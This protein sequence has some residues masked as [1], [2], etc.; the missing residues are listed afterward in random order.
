[1]EKGGLMLMCREMIKICCVVVTLVTGALVDHASAASQWI[2]QRSAG[3]FVCLSEFPLAGY[4]VLFKELTM[5][6]DDLIAML[7]VPAARETVEIYLFKSEASYRAYL[8]ER[9]PDV[10]Y[11]K[12]MF[13]KGKGPGRVFTHLSKDLATNL[14]HEGTHALL[15]AA[16]P[17]VPLWLDEGLAEYFEVPV[18]Q[19]TVGNP[20]LGKEVWSSRLGIPVRLAALEEKR[21]IADMTATDYRHAWAWVHFMLHS[22]P[23]AHEELIAYFADIQASTPPG[24]LSQRLEKRIPGAEKKLAQHFR[25]W[26]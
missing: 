21:D 22:S 14:R 8:R 24:Q 2:D 11:R 26:R 10:P 1:L 6:Q 12:A 19:R 9:Y 20:H 13:I 3:S 15:H 4:E 25:G 5:L 18:G 17:M 23:E 7:K 16:L